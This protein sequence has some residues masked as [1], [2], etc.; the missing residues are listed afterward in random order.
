MEGA[1]E[2]QSLTQDQLTWGG[3]YFDEYFLFNFFYRRKSGAA[4]NIKIRMERR[5]E[6]LITINA[7]FL[8]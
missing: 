6:G 4:G 7:V 3:D 8:P 1:L 5:D 2:G